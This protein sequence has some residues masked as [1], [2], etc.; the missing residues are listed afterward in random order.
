MLSSVDGY[1]TM[2]VAV[3][4]TTNVD[5]VPAVQDPPPVAGVGGMALTTPKMNPL[6][7]SPSE[8]VPEY[9]I[10]EPALCTHPTSLSAQDCEPIRAEPVPA[11]PPDI[12][13]HAPSSTP[14]VRIPDTAA[15]KS[16]P[17]GAPLL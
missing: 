3:P 5:A 16:G 12:P 17:M 8:A 1:G 15:A 4:T 7:P 13:H 10:T 11:A 9:G 14:S 6:E 2:I